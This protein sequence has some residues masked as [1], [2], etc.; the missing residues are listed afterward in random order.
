MSAMPEPTARELVDAVASILETTGYAGVIEA[1]PAFNLDP[2]E[3]IGLVRDGAYS[4]GIVLE[5]G[6]AE[7]DEDGAALATNRTI[8][9]NRF[10]SYGYVPDEPEGHGCTSSSEYVSKACGEFAWA[11]HNSRNL[12]FGPAH[13]TYPDA[14]V[15][16]YE[17]QEQDGQPRIQKETY[18]AH[19]V[20]MQLSVLSKRC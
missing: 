9:V 4:N 12:G 8:L 15:L 17:L 10:L 7:R 6:P 5:I 13:E 3:Y 18:N 2:S 11:L 20:P 14:W 16:H 1:D 19:H